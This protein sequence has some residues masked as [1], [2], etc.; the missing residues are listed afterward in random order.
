MNTPAIAID[1]MPTAARDIDVELL[2]AAY[3]RKTKNALLNV[4][5]ALSIAL[6][7]RPL[8]ERDLIT[9]WVIAILLATMIVS[10]DVWWFK[11]TIPTVQHLHPHLSFGRWQTR[12]LVQSG[13]TGLAWSVGP[14]LMILY[15]SGAGLT[16][17][18][19]V[20]IAVCSIAMNTLAEQQTA[21]QTFLAT[22]L[23]PPAITSALIGGPVE[24]LLSVTLV[25]G[26]AQFMLVGRDS[27]E[28]MRDRL[29]A[30][31]RLR[32]ILDS[33]QDAIIEM[34]NAGIITDWNAR[35]ESIFGS[36][37]TEMLGKNI[38]DVNV[39]EKHRAYH[40]QRLARFVGTNVD[41]TSPRFEMEMQRRNGEVFAS[42]GTI[43]AR[44]AGNVRY[45]NAFISDIT[46]RKAAESRLALFRRVFDA[47]N[48]CIV[49]TDGR[50]RF[51]YLNQALT[52]LL[53]YSRTELLGQEFSILLEKSVAEQYSRSIIES[54]TK[55]DGWDGE[56]P[57]TR[58]DGSHF[59]AF[60]R[61]GFVVN[62]QNKIQYVFNIFIDFSEELARR[63][64]LAKAK[65]AAESANKAKSEFLA[66]MSHELRTPMN[67]IL[68]FAQ[69]LEYD[70]ELNSDQKDSV[71][72]ILKGGRHLLELITEVLDLAKIESGRVHLSIEPV[73]V[74]QLVEEC[75][76]LMQP[77]A[78]VR[79][80]KL[81][82]DVPDQTAVAADRTRLKQVLLNL[83]SN[84]IKYNRD[85]GKIHVSVSNRTNS[86]FLRINIT[87]T[88]RG[89]DA[90][91][92]DLLFQAFNRLGAENSAIEGSG[93]GLTI[94]RQ[95]MQLMAGTVGVD[96]VV[97]TGSTFWLELPFAQFETHDKVP[98]Q[99]QLQAQLVFGKKQ[100]I[101]CID[102]NRVNLKLISQMLNRRDN[103][104]VLTAPSPQL[105]IELALAQSPDLILLDINM[106]DMDGYQVLEILKSDPQ[107]K[108]VPV[109]AVSAN[110]MP[111]D[112]E[113]GLAAGFTQYLVKPL[114]V[115]VL[116]KI[117]DDTLTRPR[118]DSSEGST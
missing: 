56:I 85:N 65:D 97:G 83:L 89:I 16:I 69:I 72:E 10:L 9:I 51:V 7:F 75:Q 15:S 103:L 58:K 26:L 63:T 1:P 48:Q 94:T 28:S 118:I 23:L 55:G 52:Q 39:P 12:Y 61:I 33:A 101:L 13:I 100:R 54:V 96:S 34:D 86:D 78:I 68:G 95:L 37:K 24:I 29:E 105:G 42:E 88:G 21:M 107:L 25:V 19:L 102:D 82:I 60:S 111:R 106:P 57:M 77:L 62:E 40:R 79:N 6:L 18:L 74:A 22:A 5:T 99:N 92:I 112:I 81:S 109:F 104:E 49:I 8:F 114:D 41:Q 67:A 84:A 17:C 38:V 90:A 47:T 116:L 98:E 45:F 14:S 2:Y 35:A 115:Y 36:T 76:Q 50:G 3:G 71:A 11:R 70:D 93:I 80:I 32:N 43:T 31:Q 87:D 59:I 53:G 20:L 44:S 113:R 4:G 46:K 110:A 64:E 73:D 30:K 66:S 117:V 108:S 91:N 27:N